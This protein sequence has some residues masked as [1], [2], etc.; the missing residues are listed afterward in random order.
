MRPDDGKSK[1]MQLMRSL[2]G[3]PSAAPRTHKRCGIGPLWTRTPK[4]GARIK[5]GQGVETG[6]VG[7]SDK[8]QLHYWN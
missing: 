2:G 3:V 5:E 6:A 8:L 4:V 1:R 7:P